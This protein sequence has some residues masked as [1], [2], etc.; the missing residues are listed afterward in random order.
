MNMNMNMKK[1]NGIAK[2]K[3][4]QL[5]NGN[6]PSAVELKEKYNTQQ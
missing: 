6:L 1:K 2:Q 3:R 5:K 4:T